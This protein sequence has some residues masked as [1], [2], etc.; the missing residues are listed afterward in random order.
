M[1]NNKKNVDIPIIIKKPSM[2]RGFDSDVQIRKPMLNYP[3]VNPFSMWNDKLATEKESA[4]LQGYNRAIRLSKRSFSE[5]RNSISS[6]S[7]N[8]L[9][10]FTEELKE[11][12]TLRECFVLGFVQGINRSND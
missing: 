7:E 3:I 1:N 10:E 2:K 4:Y 12:L 8:L 11:T 5:L 6:P 9:G